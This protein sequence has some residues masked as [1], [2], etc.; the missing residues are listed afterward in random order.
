MLRSIAV[1]ALLLPVAALAT[2]AT[3]V[4]LLSSRL[5]LYILGGWVIGMVVGKV[6]SRVPIVA[7]H[8]HELAHAIVAVLTGGSVRE[9]RISHG[10]AGHV[11]HDSRMIRTVAMAPY[12]LPLGALTMVVLILSG[13]AV[14]HQ[15]RAV[16][17]SGLLGLHI[18][19]ACRDIANCRSHG[20][21]GTDFGTDRPAVLL[22]WVV[23]INALLVGSVLCFA[24]SG[25]G[26]VGIGFRAALEMVRW[27]VR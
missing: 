22:P 9:L 17:L 12:V 26:G 8:A 4:V 25:R 23:T 6:M 21:A 2:G 19:F 27:C 16:I 3:G 14:S 11:L 15:M 1:G 5:R 24:A 13:L 7:T 18:W 20:W 10:G